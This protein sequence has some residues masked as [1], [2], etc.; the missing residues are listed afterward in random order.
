MPFGQQSSG[1]PQNDRY[2]DTGPVT[3]ARLSAEK[4]LPPAGVGVDPRQVDSGKAQAFLNRIHEL[5]TR[6]GF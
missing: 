2:P 1:D 3:L 4:T 5:H 6:T